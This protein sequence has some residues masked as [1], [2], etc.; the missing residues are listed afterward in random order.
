M[1][2]EAMGVT[3]LSKPLVVVVILNWNGHEDTHACLASLHSATYSPLKIIVVD[4]NSTRPG[5]ETVVACFPGVSLIKAEKNLGFAKG[6]NL[7]IKDALASGASY[8]VLLNNDTIVSPAFLEPIVRAM[9]SD[10]RL[11]AAS[12]T[13][14]KHESRK[15]NEIWYGGGRL[16]KIR[17]K[18]ILV[19]QGRLFNPTRHDGHETTEFVTGCYLVLKVSAIERAGG[20]DEDFF[21][22]VE[23]LELSWRLP[24]HG[25]RLAYIPAS[26]IWHLG[27][28]SRQY[29]PA[30]IYRG[31]I[32]KFLLMKKNFSRPLYCIWLAFFSI[33][34]VTF[35]IPLSLA[36]LPKT[37]L[38]RKTIRRLYHAAL[39]ALFAA[40]SGNLNT[41]IL[42]HSVI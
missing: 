10:W 20:L 11:G 42:P 21:F 28:R 29:S 8:V 38:R 5:I 32:S 14:L 3:E 33:Y 24:R 25:F 39:A 16:S 12:G 23:D 2:S 41:E 34:M 22:G 7:G 13:I 19:D 35:G 27:G 26:V 17:G 36:S 1:D 15:T 18:G 40:W 30:E 9:E 31:Y 4:N 6:N 37:A